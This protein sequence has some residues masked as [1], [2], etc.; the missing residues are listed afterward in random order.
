MNTLYT[1]I[2]TKCNMTCGHCGFACGAKGENMSLE[3]F[4]NVLKFHI[5]HGADSVQL[6]G[7]EPT[8]H[9]K[10]WQ[11][12]E[13]ARECVENDLTVYDAYT[14][15]CTN[16]KKTQDTM[17]LLDMA[18]REEIRLCLSLDEWHDPIDSAV[19]ERFE[20]HDQSGFSSMFGGSISIK[21]ASFSNLSKIGRAKDLIDDDHEQ[22]F[23]NA[24]V[25]K[26]NGDVYGCGCE[27]ALLFGNVNDEVVMPEWWHD[28]M[29]CK[30]RMET[31]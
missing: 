6:G 12:L 18:E 5:E 30:E 28:D 22:C 15:L 31:V 2:T 25:I 29:C 3:I 14:W 11:F 13:L 1:Q 8:I 7:G 4:K 16:G 17:K 9:P 10:F 19:V 20:K 23:C 27:D 24:P 26:P 21:R